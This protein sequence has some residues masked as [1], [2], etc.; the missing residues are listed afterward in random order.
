M[1]GWRNIWPMAFQK[2]TDLQNQGIGWLRK[3]CRS[4]GGGSV[5]WFLQSW[6]S[7]GKCQFEVLSGKSRLA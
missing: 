2:R 1:S 4:L 6:K 7:S 3:G 5:V